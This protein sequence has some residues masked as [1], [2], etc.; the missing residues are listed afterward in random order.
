MNYHNTTWDNSSL[1]IILIELSIIP[2]LSIQYKLVG[3]DYP[4]YII[5]FIHFGL[6]DRDMIHNEM[7]YILDTT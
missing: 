6:T 5:T 3:N 2:I 7:D 1:S 4:R